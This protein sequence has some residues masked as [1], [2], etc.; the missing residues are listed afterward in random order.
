MLEENASLIMYD[1]SI[2]NAYTDK[3]KMHLRQTEAL[4]RSIA[5]QH[6]SFVDTFHPQLHYFIFHNEVYNGILPIL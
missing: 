2:Y 5:N 4:L 3:W 1:M 6:V